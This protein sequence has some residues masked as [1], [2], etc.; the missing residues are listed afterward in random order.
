MSGT[1]R[2]WPGPS[3]V[4]RP[5]PPLSLTRTHGRAPGRRTRSGEQGP[6]DPRGRRRA[7]IGRVLT[8]R[9]AGLPRGSGT[10]E[11]HGPLACV[12]PRRA[13]CL[14]LPSG[15]AEPQSDQCSRASLGSRGG[16][17][18]ERAA[19]LCR[20]ADVGR[21][22]GSVGP[23]SGGPHQRAASGAAC[24]SLVLPRARHPA[25][26]EGLTQPSLRGRSRRAPRGRA[27]D[28]SRRL[29]H[30]PLLRAA[31]PRAH[32]RRGRRRRRALRRHEELCGAGR[33]A[34]QY[35]GA[36][37]PRQRVGRPLSPPRPRL[38]TR[39]AERARLRHQQSPE[40]PRVGR[41]PR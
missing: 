12:T 34:N 8:P 5:R 39:R 29:S 4:R 9:R 41:R 31:R 19:H 33:S 27:Q 13:Y 6:A 24:A 25:A 16:G 1:G 18:H 30:R 38:T 7:R 40:A 15:T 28:T 11:F 37:A 22:A 2:G 3:G 35:A 21:A 32:A 20:P 36:P 14:P 26:R 10:D 17:R 23:Q